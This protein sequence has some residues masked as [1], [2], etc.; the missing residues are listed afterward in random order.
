MISRLV[1]ISWWTHVHVKRSHCWGQGNGTRHRWHAVEFYK[2]TMQSKWFG[3]NRKYRQQIHQRNWVGWSTTHGQSTLHMVSVCQAKNIGFWSTLE[4]RNPGNSTWLILFRILRLLVGLPSTFK[5]LY[6]PRSTSL[7]EG[8]LLVELLTQVLGPHLTTSWDNYKCPPDTISCCKK[9][10]KSIPLP[11]IMPPKR[12][13]PWWV[14]CPW[15]SHTL[16]IFL[17]ADCYLLLVLVI[18][19]DKGLEEYR[20][21]VRDSEYYGWPMV[22]HGQSFHQ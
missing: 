12:E 3:L 18:S 17:R 2:A 7:H 6:F 21:L 22:S 4:D 10:L 1:V 8:L 19:R 16:F 13:S 14:L 9:L 11:L 15:H 20:W 5:L